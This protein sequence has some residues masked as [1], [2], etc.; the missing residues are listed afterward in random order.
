MTTARPPATLDPKR[1]WILALCGLGQL[2]VV[3][4]LTVVN[5][6]LPKAQIA[7]HFSND[8]R[9]WVITAYALAFGGLLLLGGRLSDRIGRKRTFLVGMAF[10]VASRSVAQRR[11]SSCSPRRGG[12][13]CLRRAASSSHVV[14]AHHDVPPTAR[15]G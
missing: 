10:A 1:W 7:L 3:L 11:T 14:T 12:A 5:I 13:G 6:A 4:D 9:Q 2:M 8:D 15:A